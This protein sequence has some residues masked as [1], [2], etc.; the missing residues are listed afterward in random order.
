MSKEK[1]KKL[2]LVS[3]TSTSVINTN[4]KILKCILSIYNLVYFRQDQEEIQVIFDLKSGI[5]IIISTN[6]AKLGLFIKKTDVRA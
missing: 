1:A 6:T 5:N 3:A 2:V 4:N